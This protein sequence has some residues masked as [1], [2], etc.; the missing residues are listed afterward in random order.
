MPVFIP[1]AREADI[2]PMRFAVP[3]HQIDDVRSGIIVVDLRDAPADLHAIA[4]HDDPLIEL[5]DDNRQRALGCGSLDQRYSS[6]V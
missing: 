3:D 5:G 1:M 6:L 2:D 4:Q